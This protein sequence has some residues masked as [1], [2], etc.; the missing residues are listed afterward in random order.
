[1]KFLNNRLVHLSCNSVIK[2]SFLEQKLPNRWTTIVMH[3][4]QFKT[5]YFLSLNINYNWDSFIILAE[6][7]DDESNYEFDYEVLSHGS[8]DQWEFV[9]ESSTSRSFEGSKEA[10][11]TQD[12]AQQVV[13]ADD[14]SS[15]SNLLTN[16]ISTENTEEKPAIQGHETDSDH[17]KGTQA[18]RDENHQAHAPDVTKLF[19]DEHHGLDDLERLMSEIGNM[20]SNLR[21][22]PDFQRR[23]MAAKLAMKMATMFGDDDE[24]GLEDI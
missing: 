24:E 13:G 17:L 5:V 12:H 20:R 11:D 2:S 6:S 22:M 16:D 23:E 7:T 19:E 8:D 9:G 18:D 14:N 1:M 4:V 3:I 15:A 21:L 10:K